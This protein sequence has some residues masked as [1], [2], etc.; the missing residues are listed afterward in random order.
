MKRIEYTKYIVIA[1]VAVLLTGLLSSCFPEQ[2]P[3]SRHN[4]NT[5][6]RLFVNSTVSDAVVV[7]RAPSD[8]EKKEK[9]LNTLDV[10]VQ[11]TSDGKFIG[12]Y[13]L[14]YPDGQAVQEQVNNFLADYWR[15]EGLEVGKTYN[16]YIA[17][18]NPKSSAV[19]DLASFNPAS[20]VYDEVSAGVAVLD[21]DN[22]I[23][24]V[25]DTTSG[26]IFK[27]YDANPG[28]SRALTSHKEFMMDGVLK[29]WT[30]NTSRQDQVFEV[31]LNRAA[32]KFVLNLKF[33]KTFLKTLTH[34]MKVNSPGDTTWTEKPDAEK[35]AITGSPAWRFN[36]FAFGAPV[37]APETQGAGVEVHNSGFNIIHNQTYTG[38]DKHVSII[39]YSYPNAWAKADYATKAPSMVVSVGFTQGTGEAAVTTYHYYRIPLVKNTITAIERNR[40]YV[41]NATIATRGS[42]AQEDQDVTEDIQY[43]V[44]PW[45]DQSNSEVI[46]NHVESIQHYYFNVNPKVYTLRGDG[47]QSVVLNYSKASGTKVNWKLFTYDE[48]GNQTAVVANNDPNAIRAWFYDAEGDFTT[49][50]NDNSGVNWSNSGPTPMGVRITQSNEGT[51]GSKGTVTVTSTALNNKGIKYIRLRVYLDEEE[52]FDDDGN[53]TMYEDIIIRHFPTDNIQS[54]VG[55]WSSYHDPNSSGSTTIYKTRDLA[56][57]QS[58]AEQYGITYSTEELTETEVINYNTYSAH[59]SEAGYAIEGPQTV[60]MSQFASALTSNDNRR[61]ANSQTNAILSDGWYYW[62]ENP[63]Q[64]NL[65]WWDDDDY[66]YYTGGWGNRRYYAYQTRYRARYTHTFT[67]NEYTLELPIASTGDW[68]DWDAADMSDHV[69]ARTY[70]I[71]YTQGGSQFIAKVYNNGIYRITETRITG[72]RYRTA[73]GTN[74]SGLTN[75]HMYVIQISSTSDN[76]V[77]GRP[78]VNPNTHQSNDNVVSPAFMI[79][80]QLG[81]VLPF[82][83]S[84]GPTNAATHCS[85]YMEVTPDGIRYTGWRLPTEA[86]ISVI[87]G[88][89]YGNIDG[90]TIPAAYQVITPVLTGMWYHSLSGT[91]V[92]ANPNTSSTTQS[93]LRC[94]RDL[95]ADEVERLNG[96]DAI[97]EKYR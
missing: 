16:I 63:V 93:Y 9:Q 4:P 85:R 13:H 3:V 62:G 54:I 27:L 77:L 84:N 41:V 69:G 1:L 34:N 49:R 11:R 39:T 72:N 14:P 28:T 20:L 19:A 43:A 56:E 79:A 83:G 82:T 35:V 29:N 76:Y 8:V 22:N 12:Q 86:E 5:D 37:F 44:L 64:V 78:Y 32:A 7:T 67:Y 88:Y 45:N 74:E 31:T 30:P 10:F 89:Q 87:T 46:E 80:S 24:W 91:P 59:S 97:Q 55:K 71:N 2:R 15:D 26:N 40:I 73:Q 96:F 81:A 18:N 70:S 36:N 65:N 75:N 53:E 17:T 92:R 42:A 52:T 95:S 38:D 33:D 57:A 51:S 21:G 60:T 50:Y 23:G 61:N 25:N 90:V 48:D 66:D 94:V 68:V 47:D 58:L 6:G